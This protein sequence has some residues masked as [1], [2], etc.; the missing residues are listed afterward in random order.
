M[1]KKSR[2]PRGIKANGRPSYD[3]CDCC[4]SFN[5]DPFTMS[6]EFRKKISRRLDAGL[7]PACGN[8]SCICKSSESAG[9]RLSPTQHADYKKAYEKYKAR[10]SSNVKPI[11]FDRFIKIYSYD[12]IKRLWK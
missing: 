4:Y 2:K 9:R 7:C 10:V 12:M 5:C 8:K 1:A 6:R 11:S 3:L